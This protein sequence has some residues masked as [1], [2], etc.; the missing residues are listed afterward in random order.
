MTYDVSGVPAE[1]AVRLAGWLPG[2]TGLVFFATE[3]QAIAW[4][5]DR[6]GQPIPHRAV[7]SVQFGPVA[8]Y[9]LVV[10]PGPYLKCE[11]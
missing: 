4:L 9:Q 5:C 8:R 3:E 10:P 7:F 1:G 2:A 11:G 6:N